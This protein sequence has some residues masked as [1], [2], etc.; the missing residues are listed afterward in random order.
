[1]LEDE[2]IA[3]AAGVSACFLLLIIVF[4]LRCFCLPR[5]RISSSEMNHRKTESLQTGIEELHRQSIHNENFEFNRSRHSNYSNIF[6]K[7][8]SSNSLFNWSDHPSL[9]SDAVENGWSQ[10]AFFGQNSSSLTSNRSTR[11]AAILGSCAAVVGDRGRVLEMESTWE[12][13]DGSTDF[14]QKIRLNPGLK[15]INPN[16]LCICTTGLPLPGPCLGNSSAFPQEAYFEITVLPFSEEEEMGKREC[17]KTKLMDENFHGKMNSESIVHAMAGSENK[18]L[19]EL[20]MGEGFLLIGLSRGGFLSSKKMPGSFPGSVGFNSNGSVYLDGIKHSSGSKDI[21]KL[22]EGRVIGCGYNPSEKEVI[23][24]IDSEVIY[25]IQCKSE[26]YG[27]PLYPMLASDM[28]LSL[29]INLGQ[30]SFRY[31][32]ANE[33]RNPNPCFVAPSANRGS[34]FDEDSKELFSMGRIDSQWLRRGAS[35]GGVDYDVESEGDL[36]EIVIDSSSSKHGRSPNS[37]L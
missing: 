35:R 22:E 15:R 36:F 4:L 13:S 3:A 11:A 20:M 19:R 6:H 29:H 24:T 16:N 21:K 12:I 37:I 10:F 7:E 23:F 1:M 8:Q 25:I 34:G 17:E 5:E 9:V 31:D 14:M 27:T 26:E 32:P 30:S 2:Q 28:D 18:N 33:Q